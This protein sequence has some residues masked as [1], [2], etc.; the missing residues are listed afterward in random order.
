MKPTQKEM[1]H[2]LGILMYKEREILRRTPTIKKNL[3]AIRDLIVEHEKLNRKIRLMKDILV[4]VDKKYSEPGSLPA[5]VSV[6]LRQLR[7][8]GKEG[9]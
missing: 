3:Q 2:V 9:K 5:S 6:L 4:D 7:N 8:V 1:L